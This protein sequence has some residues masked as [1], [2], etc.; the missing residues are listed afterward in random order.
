MRE[1]RFSDPLSDLFPFLVK[2]VFRAPIKYKK[3]S[4]K[5]YKVVCPNFV[6]PVQNLNFFTGKKLFRKHCERAVS[7][8]HVSALEC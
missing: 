5:K 2:I 6:H 8:E 7:F 3:I 1:K 4:N